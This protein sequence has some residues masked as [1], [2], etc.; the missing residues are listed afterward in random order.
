MSGRPTRVTC[1][2]PGSCEGGRPLTFSW[3]GAAL[4]S[5]SPRTLRSSVLNLTL[6]PQD[7]GTNLTCQ[8]KQQGY[9]VPVERTILLNV[10]CEFGGVAGSLWVVGARGGPLLGCLPQRKLGKC[11]PL[12]SA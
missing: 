11:S 2:L 6:R 3:V 5:L 4:D 9:R 7:H 8:V 12:P 10:S 1:N